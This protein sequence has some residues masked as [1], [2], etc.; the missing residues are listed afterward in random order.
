MSFHLTSYDH[1]THLHHAHELKRF[2]GEIRVKDMSLL[3]LGTK[4]AG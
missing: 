1:E 4:K 3:V 2:S